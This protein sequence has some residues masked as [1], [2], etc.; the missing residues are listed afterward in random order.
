MSDKIR[1]TIFTN[2]PLRCEH[3]WTCWGSSNT[4]K[5]RT[6]LIILKNINT[7]SNLSSFLLTKYSSNKWH[8]LRDCLVVAYYGGSS[9]LTSLILLEV[10]HIFEMENNVEWIYTSQSF[11]FAAISRLA[12]TQGSSDPDAWAACRTVIIIVRLHLLKYLA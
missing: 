12:L 7:K 6:A 10:C 5:L 11:K 4:T 2:G 8:L 9:L 1:R 3:R